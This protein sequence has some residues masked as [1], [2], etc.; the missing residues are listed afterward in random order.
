M[1][2]NP[3]EIPISPPPPPEAPKRTLIG[4]I[5]SHPYGALFS[6]VGIT[7]LVG[8]YLVFGT[9]GSPTLRQGAT[10]AGSGNVLLPLFREMT[11]KRELEPIPT[12]GETDLPFIP[13]PNKTPEIPTEDIESLTA[14]SSLLDS[15]TKPK[16]ASNE[17]NAG[18]AE[19]YAFIPQGLIQLVDPARNMTATQ[20]DLYDYGNEVGAYVQGFMS[21][22]M[23]MPQQMRDHAEDRG[24]ANKAAAVRRFG[25]DFIKLSAE[26]AQVKPIPGS[27]AKA[28]ATYASSYE[29]IGRRLVA[30]ADSTTDKQFLDAITAYNAGVDTLNT[31]FL[32][33]V[34]ILE[35]NT[36]RFSSSDQGSIF[37]FSTSASF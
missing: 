24:D 32:G 6:L 20:R 15:L 34:T 12:P 29:T 4:R 3:S 11:S 21:L 1:L 28:H 36:V 37:M 10:W 14:L 27:V 31:G 13:L 35:A 8:A 17:P 25:E 33:I 22:H 5:R 2:Q 16:Q 23:N 26:L 7:L 19:S 30:I 9:F 18:L